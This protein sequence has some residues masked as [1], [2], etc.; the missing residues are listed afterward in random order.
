M[1]WVAVWMAMVGAACADGEAAGDF[2]YYVMSLSWSP[3]FCAI[4][5]DAK[6]AEQCDSSGDYGWVLHGLWP[7]YEDGWPSFC[8]TVERNPSRSQSNEMVDIM[9]SSGLA[10]YQ[11]KKHGRCSGLSSVEFYDLSRKAYDSVVRPP[12]LRKLDKTVALPASVIEEAWLEVNP[13]LEKDMV[14]ITCRDGRIM[15]TR[16]CLTKDLEPRRCA[17]DARRDCTLGKALLDPIR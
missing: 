12:V 6:G 7:Q 14:T 5:G 1:R 2:D 10:W 15:E 4:E 3:N 9:G 16:I 13:D 8:N 11:W 17:P